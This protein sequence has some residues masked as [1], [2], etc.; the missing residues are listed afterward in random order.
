[1]D[2]VGIVFMALVDVIIP[3]FNTPHRFLTVALDSLRAQ[4]LS[5]W[6]A[7]VINDGSDRQYTAE[8][9]ESLRAYGDPRIQY[10]YSDHKGPAG[11][12]NVG[13]VEGRAPY[14]ALLDSDDC[15]LPHHL[16]RQVALLE[17][18]REIA[19]VHGHCDVIDPAGQ[20]VHSPPPKTGLNALSNARLFADMLRENF[21]SASS[22]VLRRSALEQV[23]G[24]DASFPCLV[25]K[26]LWLRLLNAG[27]RFHY[28]P[29]IVFRYRVHPQNISKN[30]D[31]LLATRRRIIQKA[32]SLLKDAAPLADIDWPTLKR[33]M[34]SHMYSEAADGY[35]A[36]GEYGRALKY[37][38]PF[39]AGVSRRSCALFLRSLYRSL[40]GRGRPG[41]A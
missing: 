3:V 12:R 11:S 5:D 27:A 35:L 36:R 33:E 4:T 29:E 16:S 23:G 38:S 6:K 10:L 34:I 13:I 25:D 1:V 2:S 40:A 7:W 30:T 19:L 26:E 15:W 32:E 17:A 20:L 18:N 22:V 8:L 21:V 31:L 9:E 28:D 24:F 41:K 14:V 37:S 39:Y